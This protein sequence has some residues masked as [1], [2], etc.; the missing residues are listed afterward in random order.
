VNAREGGTIVENV[1]RRGYDL[2]AGMVLI[3]GDA[4]FH[5]D[6]A[7]HRLAL[8]STRYGWFNRVN[9]WLFSNRTLSRLAYPV[10]R[11]G[12]RLT[13]RVLGRQPLSEKHAH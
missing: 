7:L 9:A 3:L 8:M 10:M 13:L 4:Y 12:R 11:T 6:E 2:D 1:R 5:G